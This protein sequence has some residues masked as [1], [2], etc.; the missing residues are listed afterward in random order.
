MKTILD[1]PDELLNEA[2]KL[3]HSKT[4]KESVIIALEEYIRKKRIVEA[5][6]MEGKLKFKKDWER[7]RHER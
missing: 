2:M 6:E 4:K 1:I 3:S 7:F 5:F